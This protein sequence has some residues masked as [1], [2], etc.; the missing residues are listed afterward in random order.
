MVLSILI[1]P[2]VKAITSEEVLYDKNGEEKVLKETLD[3]LYTELNICYTKGDATSND[4]VSGKSAYVK[5]KLV[6]GSMPVLQRAGTGGYV[7]S[8]LDGHRIKSSDKGLEQFKKLLYFIFKIN[9]Q[10]KTN[11]IHAHIVMRFHYF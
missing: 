2:K 5:G 10:L 8:K 9:T 11:R 7:N 3:E 1:M 6:N 4:I